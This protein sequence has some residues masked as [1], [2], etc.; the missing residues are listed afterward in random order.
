MLVS[1]SGQARYILIHVDIIMQLSFTLMMINTEPCK[2]MKVYK[3]RDRQIL[4]PSSHLLLGQ[5]IFNDLGGQRVGT[6][7]TR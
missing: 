6:M 5:L 2:L 3:S 7:G 4:Y 1:T